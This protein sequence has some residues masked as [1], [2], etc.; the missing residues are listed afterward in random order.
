M[1]R[2]ERQVSICFKFIAPQKT[3]TITVKHNLMP[4]MA[5]GLELEDLLFFQSHSTGGSDSGINALKRT[6]VFP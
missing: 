4:G 5:L 6:E 3:G 2:Q 1:E